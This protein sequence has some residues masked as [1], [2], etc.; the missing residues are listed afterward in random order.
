MSQAASQTENNTPLNEARLN[1]NIELLRQFKAGNLEGLKSYTGFGGLRTA[2]KQEAIQTNLADFLKMDEL[3]RLNKSTSTGYYTPDILI[4]FVYA[5]LKKLGFKQ[6]KILEPACGHGAFFERMPEDLRQNSDITGVELEPLSANIAQALYPDIKILNQG[7][8]HFHESEFDLIIGNP[9]YATFSVYDKQHKDLTGLLIHHYFIAKS[10][11]LLKNGGLLAMVVPSYVLD[12]KHGH[13]RKQTSELA[14][15]VAAYRLPND[16]FD[17]AKVT[18][19]VVIF[20][21]KDSPNTDW[22]NSVLHTLDDGTQDSISQ[23]FAD[24][25]ENIAGELGT[26]EAY[27]N[28]YERQRRG[29]RCT[30]SQEQLKARLPEFLQAAKPLDL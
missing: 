10:I 23:Y 21:R 30:A 9:P 3:E 1:A 17:D 13:S 22:V 20:Q 11:R 29:M 26:Y 18:V 5:L 15:L 27:S 12:K 6:G 7:F 28:Y 2:L 8:Q 14:E 19:D 24:H 16:L 4:D 25:P